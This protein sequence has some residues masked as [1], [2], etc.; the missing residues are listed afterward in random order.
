MRQIYGFA[1]VLLLVVAMARAD[2]ASQAS[3]AAAQNE[4]TGLKLPAPQTVNYDEG[5]VSLSADCKGTVKWLVLSTSAK[6]KFKVNPSTPNDIDIAVPPYEST[7][8]VFCVGVI[9]GKMT[10][11]A[12]TDV[13]IK[14]P[15]PPGPG[16]A[17]NPT[18]SDVKGPFHLSVIEDPAKRTN[19]IKAVI[20]SADMR[21]KLK[22]KQVTVRIYTATDPVL[23]QKK[24]DAVLQK[25]GAPVMIPPRQHRQGAGDRDIAGRRCRGV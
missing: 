25:Y 1:C 5:F 8:T 15:A 16:P 10:E 19:E 12:R 18:P 4:V 3:K 2:D 21:D 11:F 17:P 22:A 7:I 20:E 23:A 13:T 6:V 14:G 24:F 9:E